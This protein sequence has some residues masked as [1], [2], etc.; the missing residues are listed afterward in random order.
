MLGTP[1]LCNPYVHQESIAEE[2]EDQSVAEV[3]K[4]KGGGDRK[5]KHHRM[6]PGYSVIDHSNVNRT[7]QSIQQFKDLAERIERTMHEEISKIDEEVMLSVEGQV[8]FDTLQN[9]IYKAVKVPPERQN[10]DWVPSQRV[11]EAL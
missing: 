3:E 11:K 1:T 6:G 2:P 10:S 8:N 9:M 5:A 7:N 4:T